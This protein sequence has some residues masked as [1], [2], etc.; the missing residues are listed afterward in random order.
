MKL[1]ALVNATFVKTPL[2]SRTKEEALGELAR[3]VAAANIGLT[4]AEILETLHSRERQG[5]FSMS[6]GVAYP[7]AR[8]DKINDF[9][10][11]MG[12]CP[13]GIDFRAP[14]GF[15]IRMVVLFL[16]PKKHSNLYLHALALFLNC[17]SNEERAVEASGSKSARELV[18]CLDKYDANP[19]PKS[20]LDE[21]LRP[22]PSLKLSQTIAQAAETLVTSGLQ[23]L[24]VLNGTEDLV[25][26]V[27]LSGL[28]R[29]SSGEK[30]R[31]LESLKSE[32]VREAVVVQESTA[33]NEVAEKLS[34]EN[35]AVVYVL[36]GNRLVGAVNPVELLRKLIQL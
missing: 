23:R 27:S 29:F 19:K 15:A 22:V 25:G 30:G 8:T 36:R 1:S 2:T 31:T 17:F 5:P 11:A 9:V 12:T 6:K 21:V 26:E 34:Q 24:P 18:S 7:H 33:L 4:E 20:P 16:V 3:S 10:V 13:D 14:D 28:L 32:L 35:V